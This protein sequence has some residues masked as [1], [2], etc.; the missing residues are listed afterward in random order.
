MKTLKEVKATLDGVRK[1]QNLP[2]SKLASDTGLA[3]LTIDGVFGGAKDPR[4]T[5]IMTVAA[6]LGLELVLVPSSVAASFRPATSQQEN[7]Q[8]RTYSSLVQ[9]VKDRKGSK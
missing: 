6:Q 9:Q 8:Q 2:K 4:L 5:T 7:G 3:S 1:H